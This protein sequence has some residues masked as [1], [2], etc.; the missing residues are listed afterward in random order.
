MKTTHSVFG[1]LCAIVF[2]L[3][4][5]FAAAYSVTTP[6]WCGWGW[7]SVPCVSYPGN[8]AYEYQN[9]YSYNYYG[10]NNYPYNYNYYP[11]A[12]VSVDSRG[13]IVQTTC[14]YTNSYPYY[15]QY[16]YPYQPNYYPYQEYQYSHNYDYDRYDRHHGNYDHDWDHNW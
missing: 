3:S 6:Y 14:G 5:G 16:Q 13:V 15:N 10:Y 9:T 8:Y 7:S 2:A 1:V 12:P 4:P 11:C